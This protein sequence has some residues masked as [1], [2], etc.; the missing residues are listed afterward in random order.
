MRGQTRELHLVHAAVKVPAG[1]VEALAEPVVGG[2][3]DKLFRLQDV[4]QGVLH[5]VGLPRGE[6]DADRDVGRVVGAEASVGEGGE[7]ARAFSSFR[8]DNRRKRRDERDRPGDDGGDGQRVEGAPGGL[9]RVD[10]VPRGGEEGPPDLFLV[11]FVFGGRFV[12]GRFVGGVAVGV[13]VGVGS[14]VV[15]VFFFVFFFLIQVEV[16]MRLEVPGLPIGVRSPRLDD[17]VVVVL[18]FGAAVVVV[19]VVVCFS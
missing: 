17:K 2:V 15:G 14:C 8:V 18:V 19:V 9:G 5:P 12:G 11:L 10:K 4:E 1:V 13:G 7:V 6:A 16:R 3:Y